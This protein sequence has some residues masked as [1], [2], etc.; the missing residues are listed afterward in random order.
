M[1][2]KQTNDANARRLVENDIKLESDFARVLTSDQ[3]RA[4]LAKFNG[5]TINKRLDTALDAAAGEV[6]PG[7]HISSRRGDVVHKFNPFEFFEVAE[8]CGLVCGAY[9]NNGRGPSVWLKGVRP[10][11]LYTGATLD[12]SALRA[13]FDRAAEIATK[14]AEKMR[15]DLDHIEEWARKWAE[16]CQAAYDWIYGKTGDHSDTLDTSLEIAFGMDIHQGDWYFNAP[17]RG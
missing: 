4:V 9:F 12:A 3:V 17:R 5:K 14:R 10:E 11:S 6:V 1:I 15:R 7:A 13:E 8:R 16:L 2:T